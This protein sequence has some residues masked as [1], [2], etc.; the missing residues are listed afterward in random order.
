MS[1]CG[2]IVMIFLARFFSV[3]FFLAALFTATAIAQRAGLNDSQYLKD[4][5]PATALGIVQFFREA[6][7]LKR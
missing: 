7:G 1:R 6:R 2:A 4:V 5:P 3:Y